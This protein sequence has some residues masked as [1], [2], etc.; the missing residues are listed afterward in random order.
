MVLSNNRGKVIDVKAVWVVTAIP[1]NNIKWM[2]ESLETGT[3]PRCS[4]EDLRTALEIVI[5]MRESH[6]RGHVPL[7]LP[8]E[9]RSL[10]LYPATGRWDN[11][12]DHMDLDSYESIM[13]NLSTRA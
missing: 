8:L 11:K 5:A 12:K 10:K 9:D 1:P 2:V 3:P 4:G 6:R 13:R 7:R